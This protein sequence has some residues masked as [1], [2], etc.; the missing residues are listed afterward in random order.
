M[1]VPSLAWWWLVVAETYCQVF[2]FADFIHVVS[3]TVIHCY[4]ITTHNGM[5][6][7]KICFIIF[8]RNSNVLVIISVLVV[9]FD[10]KINRAERL[11]SSCLQNLRFLNFV[12]ILG[13]EGGAATRHHPPSR[14]CPLVLNE[15]KRLQGSSSLCTRLYLSKY[16]SWC[17]NAFIALSFLHAVGQFAK[18]LHIHCI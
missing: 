17:L 10:W 6:P 7:I 13:V 5:A 12:L 1:I 2:N 18:E 8:S 4:I 15:V 14:G 11:I 3:L 9:D 16:S